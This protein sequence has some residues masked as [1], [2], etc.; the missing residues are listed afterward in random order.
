M[1]TGIIR[2]DEGWRLDDHHRLDQPPVTLPIPAPAATRQQR[3]RPPAMDFIPP[4][5]APRLLWLDNL[6]QHLTAEAVK[7]GY[8][9]ASATALKTTVDAHISKMRATDDAQA[10]LDGA[11]AI[12]AQSG[13]IAAIRLAVRNMKT[14]PDYPASGSEGV[15]Q[16]R[17]PGS[18]FDA[19][20][21]KPEIKLS[22]VG[23]QI[24]FDFT[25]GEADGVVIYCRLRGSAVWNKLG[26]DLSSPY[27]DTNP[28]AQPGVAEVREYMARAILDDVEIG[29]PSDIASLT[30]GG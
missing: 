29:L 27:Y 12:E 3:T 18:G 1:P 8:P 11:R 16:L 15:L 20:T 2:L 22:I 10:A 4:K 25:K 23:G 26:I 28:L 6:S 14:L 30:F 9:P 17:G 7:M 5:R 13:T 24:R 19:N 21:F